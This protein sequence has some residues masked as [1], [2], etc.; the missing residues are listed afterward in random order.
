[1]SLLILRVVG[2]V[3]GTGTN[4]GICVLW[5]VSAASELCF[6][7]KVTAEDFKT[8]KAGAEKKTSEPM[9]ASAVS[10]NKFQFPDREGCGSALI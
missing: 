3:T 5:K 1:M 6:V 8:K 2:T 4:I 9:K 10:L 7:V